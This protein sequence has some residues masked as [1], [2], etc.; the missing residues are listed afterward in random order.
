VNEP[1]RLTAV[2][3]AF[4]TAFLGTAGYTSAM[5]LLRQIGWVDW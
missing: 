5:F 3:W 1:P 2:D 4:L